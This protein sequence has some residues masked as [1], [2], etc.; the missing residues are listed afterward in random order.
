VIYELQTLRSKYPQLEGIFFDEEVHN[1]SKKYILELTKA[2]RENGLDDLKYDVM[3]GQWPMDEEVLDNM[4]SAGYYMVRL[5]IE[6]AGEHAAKGMELQRKFNVPRLKQLMKHGTSIGLKFYG[7]FTFGGEGSTDDCDKRTL[8]LIRELID[9]E[10][11]WR[12]QLS[13]STPQPGTPFFNRMKSQGYLQDMD[14]KHFDGGNHVVVNRP[15]YPAE[16]I[17]ANFREA[18]KLYE[19][20]FNQRYNATAKENFKNLQIN[21]NGEILL[22][23]SSRMK[24]INDVVDSIHG[25]FNKE[26]TV[27]AQSGVEKELRKNPHVNEVLLYG[28]S[29]FNQKTFPE[30]LM[31]TLKKKSF[32]LGVIPFNNISGNGYSE[33]KA[34]AKRSGI[35]KLVAVNVEGK[36]FDL[37][38]P[39]DFGRAHIPS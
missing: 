3:C 28:D 35:K 4:K 6:T 21:S 33:V 29:H 38:N 36:V 2:I 1:G 27:L 9:R 34:I 22:F 19:L 10:M 5:G 25:Q 17:M 37:E 16:K 7:T 31:G 26:V 14:W 20:G 39:G 11:L 24:Q 15:E 18:E 12:F 13:I 8:D 32:S 30:S 23:R